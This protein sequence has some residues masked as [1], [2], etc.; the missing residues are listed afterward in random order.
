MAAPTTPKIIDLAIS[1]PCAC[2]REYSGCWPSL[3]LLFVNFPM[4]K[5][6][7]VEICFSE[8]PMKHCF[9]LSHLTVC[10]ETQI[11][12]MCGIMAPLP[13]SLCR[14]QGDLSASKVWGSIADLL[15]GLPL[16][17]R[18]LGSCWKAGSL[19][20]GDSGSLQTPSLPKSP[21]LRSSFQPG[22]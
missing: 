3:L 4:Q 8:S 11:S 22:L 9:L 15:S 6:P 7:I 19:T 18:F 20:A 10:W 12:R 17:P 21:N 5:N 1:H 14:G 16:A 2:H 13:N